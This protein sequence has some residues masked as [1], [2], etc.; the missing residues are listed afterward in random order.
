M[1]DVIDRTVT[2][3]GARLLASRIAAPPTDPNAITYRLDKVTHFVDGERLRADIRD[4]LR[5][6]PDLERG[7][8]PPSP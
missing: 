8:I 3:A 4:T 5:Q 1:L 7:A 2:G 6:T